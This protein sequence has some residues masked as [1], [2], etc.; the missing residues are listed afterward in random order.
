MMA[1]AAAWVLLA[2]TSPWGV[3]LAQ[4]PSPTP[5]RMSELPEAGT[6]TGAETVAVV[7][8]GQTRRTTLSLVNGFVVAGLSDVAASGDYADLLNPPT[9][10]DLAAMDDITLALVTDAG[11]MAAEDAADYTPTSGL[12]SVATSG[13]A[14]DLG[15]GTLPDARLSANIPRLDSGATFD[16]IVSFEANVSFGETV[17]LSGPALR[18][19]DLTVLQFD[20]SSGLYMGTIP[21]PTLTDNRTWTP[22]D[23]SG[24]FAL[25][26]WVEEQPLARAEGQALAPSGDTQSIDLSAANMIVLDVSDATDDVTLTLTNPVAGQIYIMRVDQGATARDLIFP[27]GTTQSLEGDNTWEPSGDWSMDIITLIWDGDA[28]RILGTSAHHEDLEP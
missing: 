18:L 19:G 9:L 26:E 20:D 24:T 8:A 2:I 15:T 10:G 7:Q 1:R 13:S 11:T 5:S 17:G 3:A 28:Y 27:S 23:A 12:A 16:G 6:I 4:T 22:P 25:E 14:S 21:P